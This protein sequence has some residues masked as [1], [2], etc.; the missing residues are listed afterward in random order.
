VIAGLAFGVAGALAFLSVSGI[1]D[2]WLVPDLLDD[3]WLG[4]NAILAALLGRAA[5]KR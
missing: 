2:V 1:V 5:V 4:A 3:L